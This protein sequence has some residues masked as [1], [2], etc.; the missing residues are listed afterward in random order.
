[1]KQKTATVYRDHKCNDES[2]IAEVK[3]DV[4][5]ITLQVASHSRFAVFVSKIC[6][7]GGQSLLGDMEWSGLRASSPHLSMKRIP[8]K[9]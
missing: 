8:I 7:R 5:K 3:C 4:K 2:S 9:V 6:M 1:M